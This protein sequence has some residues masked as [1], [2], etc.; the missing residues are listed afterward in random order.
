[1]DELP[2]GVDTIV[3]RMTWDT[4]PRRRRSIGRWDIAR[5]ALSPWAVADRPRAGSFNAEIVP[6]ADEEDPAHRPLPEPFE[7]PSR[8][9]L[10]D[11]NARPETLYP[12]PLGGTNEH[13]FLPGGIGPRGGNTPGGRASVPRAGASPSTPAIPNPAS[14]EQELRLRR[15]LERSG[16]I[17]PGDGNEAH[18]LVPQGGRSMTGRRDPSVSQDVLLQF[19]IDLNSFENGAAL[20]QRFHRRIHTNDYY[21]YVERSL[22]NLRTQEEVKKLAIPFQRAVARRGS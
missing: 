13:P 1:M 5:G 16:Q 12:S 2:Y 8:R 14:P 22:R 11:P 6:V 10:Y 9:L 4:P 20:S 17:K 18:H 7:H 21:A 15:E 19:G 3:L